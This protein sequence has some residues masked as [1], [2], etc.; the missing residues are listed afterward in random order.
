MHRNQGFCSGTRLLTGESVK[1]NKKLR[2]KGGIM[3]R[4]RPFCVERA[5]FTAPA[6]MT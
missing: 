3:K 1:K 5:G 4:C 2:K 6:R